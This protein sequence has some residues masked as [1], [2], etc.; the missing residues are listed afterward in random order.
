MSL[1][2]LRFLCYGWER[3]QEALECHK[4]DNNKEYCSNKF[5]ECCDKH[6]IRHE[7]TILHSTTHQSG[8]KDE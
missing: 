1:I 2:F 8:Q 4:S 7:K 3:N 5:V 6:D